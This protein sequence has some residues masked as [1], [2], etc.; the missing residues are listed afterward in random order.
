MLHV[1]STSNLLLE[2]IIDTSFD[3]PQL[4]DIRGVQ[5]YFGDAN[6]KSNSGLGNSTP[7]LATDLG[8]IFAGGSARIGADADVPS[9]VISASATDFV[10]IANLDDV[11]YY[12]FTIEQPGALGATLTPRG[13]IFTQAEEGFTPTSFNAN[14]RNNLALTLFDTDGET[15]LITADEN[16][17]GAAETISQLLLPAAGTYFARI[18]GADDTIQLYDLALSLA[19]LG[20]ADYNGD[21]V[22]NAADYTVWRNSLGET[23]SLATGA[24][25][26]GPDGFP[27]GIVDAF[28]YTYWKARYGDSAGSG[29]G[30]SDSESVP[31]PGALILAALGAIVIFAR[32]RT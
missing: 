14:A 27:D 28:D 22:V 18:A 9:Q 2:P 26:S 25:G 29:T 4:D 10:S 19:A 16:L 30:A 8:T 5:Y 1:S 17:S 6:E 12:Q 23:V 24:D 31:E 13:G 20:N 15:I 7:A 11:D 32:Q 21:G 3:G